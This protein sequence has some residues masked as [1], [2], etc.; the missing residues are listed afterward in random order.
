MTPQVRRELAPPLQRMAYDGAGDNGF[1]TVQ[2]M[3]YQERNL[4]EG[5]EHLNS[6]LIPKAIRNN[7]TVQTEQ[8][9]SDK[10]DMQESDDVADNHT[11]QPL[12]EHRVKETAVS[13][14]ANDVVRTVN[15]KPAVNNRDLSHEEI[16]VAVA[17]PDDG[18]YDI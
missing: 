1:T 13:Q 18:T 14:M 10:L 15:V 9:M 4:Y 6:A 12:T 8:Q 5:S 17:E 16:P 7:M 11:Y 3:A 2:K